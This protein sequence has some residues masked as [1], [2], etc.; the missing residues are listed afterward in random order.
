[1]NSTRR[2]LLVTAAFVLTGTLLILLR[3]SPDESE[4]PAPSMIPAGQPEPNATAAS[5]PPKH[6]PTAPA[7]AEPRSVTRALL[8]LPPPS[9]LDALLSRSTLLGESS[10]PTPDGSFRRTRVWETDGTWPFIRTEETVS[11]GDQGAE[12]IRSRVAMVA[13][14]V[15]IQLAAAKP[16]PQTLTALSEAGLDLY[17][18]VTPDGLFRARLSDF[19]DPLSLGRAIGASASVNRVVRYVEPDFIVQASLAPSDSRF[20]DQWAL[21]AHSPQHG[22]GAAQAWEV[23]TD[24]SSVV[25]AIIDTGIRATHEDLRDSLWSNPGELSGN[26]IDDDH[27]GYVDDVHGANFLTDSGNPSDDNGHGTHVSGIV[28]AAGNNGKGIS[29]VAWRSRLMSLKILD[30]DG[31]GTNSAAIEA[32]DYAIGEGASVIN[33]SWGSDG[34]SNALESAILRADAAG[35]FFIASA[36]NEARNIDITP[37][38]PAAYSA[39]NLIAVA[40]TDSNGMLATFS[41]WGPQSVLLGAPGTTILSTWSSSDNAY[42]VEGGTSMAAPHVTGTISL[43]MAEDADLDVSGVRSRLIRNS[44]SNE[45]LEG[46]T[47]LGLSLNAGATIENAVQTEPHDAFEDPAVL[48]QFQNTRSAYP[49]LATTQ[50]GEPVHGRE[51]DQGTVWYTWTPA[52]A[53]RV[54]LSVVSEV[55]DSTVVVYTG[56]QPENLNRIADASPGQS[57]EFDA[58]PGVAFRIVLS[59]ARNAIP[60]PSTFTLSARPL[61]DP[62]SGAG[63][64]AGDS[65]VLSGSTENATREP[66]EPASS[67]SGRT[68]WWQWTPSATGVYVLALDAADTS[69]RFKLYRSEGTTLA[70]L[71]PIDPVGTTVFGRQASAYE[72]V[73]GQAYQLQVESMGLRGTV[74]SLVGQPS[75][76]PFIASQP[77]DAQVRPTQ[78]LTLEVVA[79]GTPPLAYQWEFNE[80]AIPGAT[81]ARLTV[82][83]FGPAN[84]GPYRVIIDSPTGRTTSRTAS[85]DLLPPDLRIL[86]QPADL[87]VDEGGNAGFAVLAVGDGQL[88]YQWFKDG[89][90]IEGATANH[91]TLTGVDPADEAAYHVRVASPF[92]SIQS[93]AATLH[94]SSSANLEPVWR[95]PR[96]PGFDLNAS[97]YADGIFVVG[98]QGGHYALSADGIDWQSATVPE[99][100]TIN[101]IFRNGTNW[102]FVG[103]IAPFNATYALV[104]PDFTTWVRHQVSGGPIRSLAT[105]GTIIVAAGSDSF[106]SVDAIQWTRLPQGVSNMHAVVWA[107]HRFM[108]GL[109]YSGGVWTSPD[110]VDWTMVSDRNIGNWKLK[111]DGEWFYSYTSR[112]RDGITW[113]SSGIG[114]NDG[115]VVAKGIYARV[116]FNGF[117][118]SNNGINWKPVDTGDVPFSDPIPLSAVTDGEIAIVTG[119]RGLLVT[120]SVGTTM[121]VRARPAPY[122]RLHLAGNALFFLSFSPGESSFS[123]DGIEWTPLPVQGYPE[124]YWEQVFFHQDKFYLVNNQRKIFA[125]PSPLALTEV[126]RDFGQ[127]ACS[128]FGSIF[129]MNFDEE[130]EQSSNGTTWNRI[131][132]KQAPFEVERS[133]T[134]GNLL[135]MTSYSGVY[136]IRSD[137]TASYI[138][139][140]P[141]TNGIAHSGSLYGSVTGMGTIARSSDGLNWQQADLIRPSEYAM[142]IAWGGGRF[143]VATKYGNLYESTDLV[144][145]SPV[146]RF[147]GGSGRLLFFKGRFWLTSDP[148]SL[149]PRFPQDFGSGVQSI[150]SPPG[151]PPVVAIAGTTSD[152]VVLPR[153][154]HLTVVPTAADPDGDISFQDL[155]TTGSASWLHDLGDGAYRFTPETTGQQVLTLNAIDESGNEATTTLRVQVNPTMPIVELPEGYLGRMNAAVRFRDEWWAFGIDA[156]AARSVNG[157]DWEIFG[158]DPNMR[159]MDVQPIA[160]RL[161]GVTRDFQLVASEDGINWTEVRGPA[162]NGS[163]DF[164]KLVPIGRRLYFRETFNRT[165]TSIDGIQWEL[166]IGIDGVTSA[167]SENG[168]IIATG[169]ESGYGLSVDGV[170]FSPLDD[171]LPIG[172]NPILSVAAGNGLFILTT[173][174]P[175]VLKSTEPDQAWLPSIQLPVWGVGSMRVIFTGG[176]FYLDSRSSSTPWL[177]SIDG[178]DWQSCH[179]FP[180]TSVLV[181]ADR[182]V[183][184]GTQF[185]TTSSDG[186]NWTTDPARPPVPYGVQLLP[187]ENGTLGFR[188]GSASQLWSDGGHTAFSPNGID[189]PTLVASSVFYSS[190]ITHFGGLHDR[191]FLRES[192]PGEATSNRVRVSSGFGPWSDLVVNDA[193][194]CAFAVGSE[195]VWLLTAD[196]GVWESDAS[197]EWARLATLPESVDPYTALMAYE[198]GRLFLQTISQTLL[199]STDGITWSEAVIPD[200]SDV[201]ITGI[202]HGFGRWVVTKGT[203]LH[204]SIDLVSWNSSEQSAYGPARFLADRF[205]LPV[206]G[207]YKKSTDGLVWTQT[208]LNSRTTYYRVARMAGELVLLATNPDRTDTIAGGHFDLVATGQSV[209]SGSPYVYDAVDFGTDTYLFGASGTLMRVSHVDLRLDEMS[210]HSGEIRPG[211][212]GVVDALLT[213]P[214]Q[215]GI[216]PG[217]SA[218]IE[219]LLTSVSGIDRLSD[220]PVA[221]MDIDLAAGFAAGEFRLLQVPIRMP[222]VLR[223]GLWRLRAFIDSDIHE[224]NLLNNSLIESGPP[225]N[226]NAQT[227]TTS[228]A[229]PGSFL[230]MAPGDRV[231]ARDSRVNLVPIAGDNAYFLRWDGD[232]EG[233]I[234]ATTVQ[235]DRDR[236]VT[237]IFSNYLRMGISIEGRGTVETDQDPDTL[238][239]GSSVK[240]TA[241]PSPG[242][243]FRNWSDGVEVTEAETSVTVGSDLQVR[244][245]FDRTRQS[246]LEGHFTEAERADPDLSGD[247][248]DPDLDGL[249]NLTEFVLD[250]DPR[251]ADLP[252][253]YE[254]YRDG[255]E[256]SFLFPRNHFLDGW[257]LRAETSTN[258]KDWTTAGLTE[259]IIESDNVFDYIE[260]RRTSNGFNP[261]FFRLEIISP[262]QAQSVP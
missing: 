180:G 191:R 248:A 157:V 166:V 97:H 52:V 63:K 206:H 156:R 21:Q 220:I 174:G 245:H 216:P 127:F 250:L 51:A 195:K 26:G 123:L 207:G 62:F 107:N 100:M 140:L 83:D 190:A 33:A 88:A 1:M 154:S 237:A 141:T 13:D 7:S 135:F 252:P 144:I 125:G 230:G 108:A 11:I 175:V 251:M 197:D 205:Y 262:T 225:H 74:F 160:D 254:T 128:A 129:R 147:A 119:K 24:A 255:N 68:V 246:F 115:I 65:F 133:F 236:S 43:L 66:L 69:T 70:G 249:N 10:E 35:V 126:T 208:N 45:F 130:I 218:T 98:G 48:I 113:E 54:S 173:T 38:Y 244:A 80:V 111:S 159:L 41:N 102:V 3:T 57:S 14:H 40:A 94:V 37:T 90:P 181:A 253:H 17:D 185:L 20:A 86:K 39:P 221:R 96:S 117:Q 192:K 53:A 234:G 241:L 120:G 109:E 171:F 34:R 31:I 226:L 23:R 42:K 77:A 184:A 104:T 27:N 4:V 50:P 114:E 196:R 8:S 228:V 134:A 151:Q 87:T 247:F 231:V 18:E 19:R 238:T 58:L 9:P 186:L 258:L 146:G 36:G 168:Y 15:L 93:M 89:Q 61:N 161:I 194:A 169:W 170:H 259:K 227:L 103:P 172:T 215:T 153:Y 64:I 233:G 143:L 49:S 22:I 110:G 78:T 232:V 200:G 239:I 213:N 201:E 235:M 99:P 165:L 44:I 124:D 224:A 122:G 2:T 139:Q 28:G 158:L 211:A 212:T 217:H 5:P 148:E 85:V 81:G 149:N 202:T 223:P 242:W 67:G 136:A 106:R 92:G 257:V 75:Q 209:F 131:L 72:L 164:P 112:S 73:G 84:V 155:T 46:R 243:V 260:V 177:A 132:G 32:I 145:W 189:W 121:A 6:G 163:L 105:D 162:P 183:A 256:I 204:S 219:I 60:T 179:G 56:S 167:V 138:D 101:H 30:A 137:G 152:L 12:Q 16:D 142:G 229:G 199:H 29:G 214:T 76:S 55:P 91:F 188:E 47:L 82:P 118:T 25:V 187:G 71:I 261:V 198:G 193:A 79:L 150:G 240:L 203:R 176:R 116:D 222:D 178:V 210:L 59:G 95:L 182:L